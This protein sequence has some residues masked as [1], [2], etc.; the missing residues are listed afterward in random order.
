[1]KTYDAVLLLGLKLT[2]DGHATEELMGRIRRA[3]QLMQEHRAPLVIPCGGQT[4]NTPVSE[5]AVMARELE[6]LGIDPHRILP[7]DASLYTV[8][9]IRN[10]RDLLAKRGLTRPRVLLVTS[11]YHA[12]RAATMARSMGFM[13]KSTPSKTPSGAQKNKRRKMEIFYLIN[14]I[15]G[16]ETGKRKRPKWYDAAV[17][18]L[19]K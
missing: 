18:K 12:F 13:V 14:Y 15:T 11:D 16:W 6:Q 9:N 7:E 4:E 1:M 5:A 10:A 17:K 2:P 19:Q 3:A 8:E